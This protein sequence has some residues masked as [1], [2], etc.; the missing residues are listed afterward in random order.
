MRRTL[1]IV[2]TLVAF[3]A[4]AVAK[5]SQWDDV[6]E[7]PGDRLPAPSKN[8]PRFEK[9]SAKAA[10]TKPAKTKV[11]AKAK[12]APRRATTKRSRR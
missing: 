7:K 5:P 10:N 4:P 12:K 1:L 2:I 9:T 6:I 8:A 11:K 3:S